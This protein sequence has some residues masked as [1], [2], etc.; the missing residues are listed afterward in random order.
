MAI[1]FKGTNKCT[2]HLTVV[3]ECINSAERIGLYAFLGARRRVCRDTRTELRMSLLVVA[4]QYRRW[5]RRP[6]MR[7]DT[8]GISSDVRPYRAP[9]AYPVYYVLYIRVNDS[10]AAAAEGHRI[11]A[12]ARFG[13]DPS[14]SSLLLL[15]DTHTVRH[16]RWRRWQEQR[17]WSGGKRFLLLYCNDGAKPYCLY[18]YMLSAGRIVCSH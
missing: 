14:W 17:G 15:E 4:A 18:T 11:L 12:D 16:T 10:R 13:D 6:L 5:F 9:T 7:T 3:C 1:N 2:K 8:D